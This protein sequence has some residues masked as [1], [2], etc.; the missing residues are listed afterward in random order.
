M[1]GEPIGGSDD[2]RLLDAWIAGDKS[3]GDELLQRYYVVL[4]RFFANKVATEV[5]DLV[6]QTMAALLTSCDR[7]ERRSTFRA[8]L[9]SIARYQL[10]E[11]VRRKQ[12]TNAVI[13]Y[14]AVSAFDL[15]PSPSTLY[16]P[17]WMNMPNFMS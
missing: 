16:T 8:Y 15:S 2:L 7:F 6:Q 1:M 14:D 13:E 4:Y 11:F 10:Y 12:R 17:Q 9:L 3:A 5:D